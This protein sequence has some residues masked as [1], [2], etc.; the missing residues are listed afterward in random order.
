MRLKLG[1]KK[2]VLQLAFALSR[3]AVSSDV[4]SAPAPWPNV[5][6]HTRPTAW[7]SPTTAASPSAWTTRRG[8]APATPAATFTGRTTWRPRR[9]PPPPPAWLSSWQLP[10]QLLRSPPHPTV[11]SQTLRSS[12]IPSSIRPTAVL[13]P[14][15]PPHNSRWLTISRLLRPQLLSKLLREQ[16]SLQRPLRRVLLVLVVLL[17]LQLPPT[18]QQPQALLF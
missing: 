7:A 11:Q 4:V 15:P 3:S 13:I 8:V 12:P 5:A 16:L 18:R 1:V 2:D 14:R 17:H 6:S 10:P 9:H